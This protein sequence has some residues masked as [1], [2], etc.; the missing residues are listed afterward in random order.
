M[1]KSIIAD[2]DGM[3]YLPD[4]SLEADETNI[5][6]IQSTMIPTI[7]EAMYTIKYTETREIEIF[8]RELTKFL[9]QI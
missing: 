7:S 2:G 3:A 8:E 1:I 5:K 6:Q 4:F 9:Q